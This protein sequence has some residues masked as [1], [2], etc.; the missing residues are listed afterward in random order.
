MGNMTDAHCFAC[1][2]D[3][4]LTIGGTR[5]SYLEV[6]WW[7]VS[8]PHCRGVTGANL[9]KAPLACSKCGA[10]DVIE[11]GDARLYSGDGKEEVARWFGRVLT[12]GHYKCPLCRKSELRIG[13]NA[14]GK[15]DRILF[16]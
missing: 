10:T 7:P 3:T 5:S 4:G 13:T 14:S 8:C 9:S 2:Y 1:G 11:L 15:H 12:D 6:S 16:D